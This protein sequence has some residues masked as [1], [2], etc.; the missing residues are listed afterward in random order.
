MGSDIPELFGEGAV[1]TIRGVLEAEVLVDLEE[2]LVL[3]GF[4]EEMLD[5]L[6][7]AEEADGGFVDFFVGGGC[8]EILVGLPSGG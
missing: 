7:F 3:P 8:G 1:L 5:V 2:S 4:F 6:P